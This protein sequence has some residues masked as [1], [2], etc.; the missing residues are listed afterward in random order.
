MKDPQS[1]DNILPTAV[2]QQRT[3][4]LR[5]SARLQNATESQSLSIITQPNLR[6]SY[7][8]DT[9]QKDVKIVCKESGISSAGAVRDT[10]EKLEDYVNE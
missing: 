3:G 6:C 9:S 2:K 4:N 1:D 5:R 7:T 8:G 10:M